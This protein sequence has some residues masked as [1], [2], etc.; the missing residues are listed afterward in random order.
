[1]TSP[2]GSASA[3]QAVAS[4]EATAAGPAA[5]AQAAAASQ[6]AAAGQA[7]GVAPRELPGE[8]SRPQ[9]SPPSER[10]FDPGPAWARYLPPVA[11]LLFAFFGITRPS[12]WRDEAA[13]IAAVRRPFGDLITMLGNVDAVHSLYYILMWPIEHLLGSG[14]FA[15]RF[16]SAVAAAVAA[17]AIAAIGRRLISSWA[18]LTAGLVL[19]ILPVTSRYGQ[20]ARSYE[21]VVA[22]ATIASYLLVRL[23]QAEPSARRRWIIG[24]G[25]S[26]G[27]LGVLNIFGLLMI[28]AHALT[29][30]LYLRRD[31]R[32]P[33]ARRLAIG[34]T[35]AVIAGV[36]MAGPLL[37]YGWMQRAQIAWLSVNTSSSGPSTLFSLSGSYLT[38]TAL[39]TVIAVA[40]VLGMEKS[41]QQ[42]AT[43]WPGP[44]VGLGLP[45]LIVPPFILFAVSVVHPVYTSRYILMCIPAL[46]LIVGAA[47]ASFK[48]LACGVCVVVV[49]VAGATAQATL[50]GPAGHYDDIRAIDHLVNLKAQ[51][52]DAVLYT[53]P[54]AES[55]GYAYSYGLSKLPNAGITKGPVASGT[56]AGA[57]ATLA[58]VRAALPR[59]K[60]IWVVE[61]NSFDQDPA[62]VN[63]KGLPVGS[64][65]DGLPFTYTTNWH[66]H[67]DYLVL[68]TRNK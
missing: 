19:A 46:A 39:I 68:F 52:G 6:A 59:Y 33:A 4:D 10:G 49:L 31:L 20:E 12:Y 34:W 15:M 2:S 55:F 60:R 61:I 67:G 43:S 50:R 32:D 47:A 38:T 21:M 8:P 16:P 35:L 66:A 17:A 44:M 9:A 53:N 28:P 11:A 54:N 1:M 41:R 25:A 30:A 51:R 64:I 22:M 18:G 24:Y 29:V 14:E 5:A 7:A 65:F 36:I 27:L 23:L 45:W 56:L 26:I 13:T 63:L 42:R 3:G 62:L 58:Q 48:R 57:P 40:L 37:A